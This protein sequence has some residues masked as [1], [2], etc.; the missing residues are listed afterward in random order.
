MKTRLVAA[1]ALLVFAFFLVSGCFTPNMKGPCCSKAYA[2]NGT[3]ELYTEATPDTPAV[4]EMC[5]GSTLS[6]GMKCQTQW[7]V[8]PEV[9]DDKNDTIYVE[10]GPSGSKTTLDC[11]QVSAENKTDPCN[12]V[13]YCMMIMTNE[14]TT[15]VSDDGCSIGQ[16]VNGRC[17][18]YSSYPV[19]SER[20]ELSYDTDCKTM[21]CGAIKYSPKTSLLPEPG[22]NMNYQNFEAGSTQNLYNAMCN[23]YVLD[24]VTMKKLKK[25]K[26]VFVNTFRFGVGSSISDYEEARF[27]FPLSDR[28][29]QPVLPSES[30]GVVTFSIKDR[31]VDY[32]NLSS[33]RAELSSVGQAYY[34]PFDPTTLSNRSTALGC[35]DGTDFPPTANG[36]Y[37]MKRISEGYLGE[38]GSGSLYIA[39]YLTPDMDSYK[40]SLYGAYWNYTSGSDATKEIWMGDNKSLADFECMSGD[41]CYSGICADT[42]YGYSRGFCTS[43]VTGKSVN[44]LCHEIGTRGVDGNEMR[45]EPFKDATPFTTLT[46]SV[47][48]MTVTQPEQCCTD[49]TDPDTGETTT[50]CNDYQNCFTCGSCSGED[51][52]GYSCCSGTCNPE[53]YSTD[54]TGVQA[55]SDIL[56]PKD[57]YSGFK[58]YAIM[59]E[60]EF[61]TSMLY[62]RCNLTSADYSV[63]SIP[64][65]ELPYDM[66]GTG[67]A[68]AMTQLGCLQSESVTVNQAWG[69]SYTKTRCIK[70]AKEVIGIKS[71][72]S[73][74]VD[75]GGT[76]GT[77]N[78]NF[79]KLTNSFGWCEACT[80]ANMVSVNLDE[81]WPYFSGND[82]HCPSTTSGFGGYAVLGD[83]CLTTIQTYMNNLAM[84]R[85]R[86]D[87]YL[88]A[89]VMPVIWY[90][91]G[92]TGYTTISSSSYQV[93]SACDNNCGTDS[94]DGVSSNEKLKE[95][96]LSNQIY[97]PMDFQPFFQDAT[98][99]CSWTGMRDA[100]NDGSCNWAA[101]EDARSASGGET[102]SSPSSATGR[103]S[104]KLWG[105]S[106]I[107]YPPHDVTDYYCSWT[108]KYHF[109]NKAIGNS[110]SIVVVATDD[111]SDSEIEQRAMDVKNDNCPNCLVAL[112]SPAM[113]ETRLKDLFGCDKGES[114]RILDHNPAWQ[115]IDIILYDARINDYVADDKNLEIY[116][117]LTGR[118][119]RVLQ[120]FGK[121][122]MPY[123]FAIHNTD[124]G[125]DTYNDTLESM[126]YLL[127]NQ[128]MVVNSGLFSLFYENWRAR[129]PAG[130]TDPYSVSPESLV[131][132]TSDTQTYKNAKFCAFERA[133]DNYFYPPKIMTVFT[134]S[135]ALNA[136]QATCTECMKTD[137]IIGNCNRTCE[138]GVDCT[139][140]TGIA[141]GSAEAATYRCP[142]GVAIEPCRLCNDSYYDN[143]NVSCNITQA[144]GTVQYLINRSIASLNGSMFD[145]YG[146][147]VSSMPK[148]E[149]C[150]NSVF[151]N[152]TNE[153][154][155]YTYSKM[156]SGYIMTAPIRYPSSGNESLDCSNEMHGNLSFCGAAIPVRDYK[157]ECAIQR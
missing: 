29:C 56:L 114:C 20:S 71:F 77:A 12:N 45:C 23:F 150:C 31:F 30:G 75:D 91:T 52:C 85:K 142:S 74:A 51:G 140:P 35:N 18:S 131:I 16:C 54:C 50:A 15:C 127:Y 83:G 21:I 152:D 65:S 1:L 134:E 24:N 119:R 82:M 57:G 106:G 108:A 28:F 123:N 122:S 78:T 135:R 129:A 141:E 3:C 42:D 59:D 148:S 67:A 147:Y 26:N 146:D 69:S 80:F 55:A 46:S 151:N 88:K 43:T 154:Y 93:G 49:T 79:T 37:L 130:S 126:K 84:I 39:S 115:Y 136:S 104:A 61:K 44:C 2:Y 111:M 60:S 118:S 32:L 63:Y 98:T 132:A 143:A 124:N 149:K 101:I 34:G 145:A 62:T 9:N 70:A 36:G 73:C 86:V 155:N 120:L 125:W 10:Y 53:V 107:T 100:W 8:F 4:K 48:T 117:K 17:G 81:Y 64:G 47:C 89:G 7:C 22:K 6:S 99:S 153:T 11:S 19:C 133:V 139:L 102:Y 38:S 96:L 138:N 137:Q 113:N 14:S 105:I 109:L 72:G 156:S 41:D 128:S 58:G 90:T 112:Y 116:T 144:D 33:V 95:V 76:K 94:C 27:Y 103:G 92:A 87:A 68:P 66:T 13:G 110:A 157:I 25:A 40:F 97:Y 5:D 121:P